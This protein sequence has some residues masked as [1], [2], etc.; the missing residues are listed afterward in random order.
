MGES[1]YFYKLNKLIEDIINCTQ[2]NLP[3]LK[4]DAKKLF[5][6]IYNT[7]NNN[8]I[9]NNNNNNES[10]PNC[11][12]NNYTIYFIRNLRLKYQKE[13]NKNISNENLISYKGKTICEFIFWLLNETK[14]LSFQQI[15]KL[16]QDIIET[17]P[18]SGVEPI[19]NIVSEFVKNSQCYSINKEGK[20]DILF[21]QNIFLK[22]TNNN[23]D[24][25]LRGKLLLLFCD[26]FSIEEK[27][28]INKNGIYSKNQINEELSN[29]SNDNSDTVINEDDAKM[30][31]E[32]NKDNIKL[33]DK[34]KDINNTI[35]IKDE[36]KDEKKDNK[37]IV[38]EEIKKIE[39][40]DIKE[41]K[42]DIKND[43]ENIKDN[44]I[45]EEKNNNETS[46]NIGKKQNEKVIFYEQFWIIQK[47]LINPFMVC[48]LFYNLYNNKLFYFIAI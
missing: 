46:I 44:K 17:I 26:F 7:L 36:N 18:F 27:S 9:N 22:R 16:L 47:I 14:I 40:N 43:K 45:K 20:L 28:G 41:I 8:N 11:C 2:E 30:D 19:F 32:E 31:I 35:N 10:I 39:N 24:N 13:I 12:E 6:D 1:K 5:N 29:Y 4:N 3:S 23:L 25:E 34:N 15:L 21:L 38:E 33:S 42:N 37:M 48:K